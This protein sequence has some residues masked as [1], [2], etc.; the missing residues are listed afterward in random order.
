MSRAIHAERW[1]V[2]IHCMW[3]THMAQT[4]GIRARCWTIRLLAAAA[5]QSGRKA[6]LSGKPEVLFPKKPLSLV[7]L[8]RL[9]LFNVHGT[10]SQTCPAAS[11]PSRVRRKI[12][13]LCFFERHARH[14]VGNK[15]EV[16]PGLG[17][18]RDVEINTTQ[19]KP[20]CRPVA[21]LTRWDGGAKR[22]SHRRQDPGVE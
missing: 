18:R 21:E 16:L 14:G 1:D 22:T 5:A 8:M 19:R 11:R 12:P 7:K 20:P 9:M 10:T 13:P 4:R 2:D 15:A 6:I 3:P 17:R